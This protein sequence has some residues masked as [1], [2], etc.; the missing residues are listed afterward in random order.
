MH[1]GVKT[2]VFYLE[3]GDTKFLQKLIKLTKIQQ[4]L[5]NVKFYD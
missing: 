4:L 1:D 2:D 3:D 5:E